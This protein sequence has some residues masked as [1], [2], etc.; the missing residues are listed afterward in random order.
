MGAQV[1]VERCFDVDFIRSVMGEIW[2]DTCEDGA[3]FDDWQ[4]SPDDVWLQ[5]SVDGERVAAYRLNAMNSSTFELHAQV[6]PKYR[7]LYTQAISDACH[8]WLL[9]N[10]L[11]HIKKFVAFIPSKYK[12]VISYAIK[13]GWNEEG[14]ITKSYIKSGILYDIHIM[15][16]QREEIERLVQCPQP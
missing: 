4:P 5:F 13:S 3:V 8:K 1:L 10:C 16:I 7:K 6:I 2:D 9:A 11:P 15:G 14:V 12:N